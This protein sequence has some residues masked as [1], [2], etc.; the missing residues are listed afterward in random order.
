[1]LFVP[2]VKVY[3]VKVGTAAPPRRAAKRIPSVAQHH[4]AN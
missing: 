3:Q 1:M 2:E 4:H